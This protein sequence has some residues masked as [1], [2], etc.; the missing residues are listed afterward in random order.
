MTM[1]TEK[2]PPQ[3]HHY[4]QRYHLIITISGSDGETEED[5]EIVEG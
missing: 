5:I 2:S 1:M 3:C 4:N